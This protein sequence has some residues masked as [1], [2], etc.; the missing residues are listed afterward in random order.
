M[1]TPPRISQNLR[2][3]EPHDRIWSSRSEPAPSRMEGPFHPNAYLR[4][5]PDETITLW[6][7]RLEMGTGRAHAS[8]RDPRR[9]TRCPTGPRVRVEQAWPGGQFKGIR[10]HT[11]GSSEQLGG[12]PEG[13]ELRRSPAAAASGMMLSVRRTNCQRRVGES[14]P[15]RIVPDRKQSAVS[16]KQQRGAIAVLTLWVRKEQTSGRAAEA[17]RPR[18]KHFCYH[19]RFRAPPPKPVRKEGFDLPSAREPTRRVDG[20]RSSQVRAEY[21]L[22]GACTRPAVRTPWSA[23]PELGATVSRFNRDEVLALPAYGT[24]WRIS[25]GIFIRRLRWLRPTL[26][27]TQGTAALKVDMDAGDS[28][29]VDRTYMED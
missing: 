6:V 18:L 13:K 17:A 9:G 29:P 24:S 22:D 5:D 20:P 1:T 14:S 26:G 25:K 19:S 10:M 28:P 12:V 7:T 21:G 27:R 8:S 2:G 3:R 15:R 16:S 11:S 23:A 4:I